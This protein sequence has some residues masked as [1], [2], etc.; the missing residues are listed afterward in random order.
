MEKPKYDDTAARRRLERAFSSSSSMEETDA[1]EK[2]ESA[3]E[4]LAS[5]VQMLKDVGVE[6]VEQ[7]AS[8]SMNDQNYRLPGYNN[9][10][11]I[12]RGAKI[13]IAKSAD[14]E[15]LVPLV[16]S[17]KDRRFEG[18]AV[19]PEV[20]PEPGKL[21]PRRT[22]LDVLAEAVLLYLGVT[23]QEPAPTPST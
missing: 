2:Q 3:Q 14:D 12:R 15:L 21:G 5:L 19:D 8:S 10:N 13:F 11:L 7:N 4:L 22:A 1:Q 17:T 16:W 18:E 20:A 23:K 6:L 9:A